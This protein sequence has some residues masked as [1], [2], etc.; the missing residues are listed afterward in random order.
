MPLKGAC[1]YAPPGTMA[2][3]SSG[4]R[5]QE[6][7]KVSVS[8]LT[9]M[10]DSFRRGM[11]RGKRQQ[12]LLSA[13]VSIRS[14]G[15]REQMAGR[16]DAQSRGMAAGQSGP[17]EN[18]LVSHPYGYFL[19]SNSSWSALMYQRLYWP[20]GQLVAR[21]QT[22]GSVGVNFEHRSVG[23]LYSKCE[24]EARFPDRVCAIAM[25]IIENSCTQN[26]FPGPEVS[27]EVE[28]IHLHASR[29]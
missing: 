29:I 24:N 21:W 26:V 17:G 25:S 11:E 7:R 23:T 19:A 8:F 9:G 14:S 22:P 16:D 27:Q 18:S 13:D 1:V 10:N 4:G 12:T 2:K 20:G 5:F 3:Y 28:R 15:Y 6:M